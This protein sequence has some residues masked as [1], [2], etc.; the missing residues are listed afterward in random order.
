LR[1]KEMEISEILKSR[2]MADKAVINTNRP[3]MTSTVVLFRF[4]A[5]SD[6]SGT[7][8]EFFSSSRTKLPVL[9]FLLFR[10]VPARSARTGIVGCAVV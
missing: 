7:Q 6:R 2:A 3:H 10:T 4:G 1:S 8:P 5:A 9:P